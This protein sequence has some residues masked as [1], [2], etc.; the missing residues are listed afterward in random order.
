MRRLGLAR[1]WFAVAVVLAIVA[2]FVVDGPAGGVVAAVAAATFIFACF[3]G[4]VGKEVDDR[5]AG[6]GWFGGYF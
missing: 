2:V 6:A 1:V 5:A 4:L 3:R